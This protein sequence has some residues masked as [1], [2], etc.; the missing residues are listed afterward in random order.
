MSLQKKILYHGLPSILACD[1]RCD[2]AWGI[3]N[4]PRLYFQES[5]TEPRALAKGEEPRHDDD[6]V[7][8]GDGELGIAPADPGTYECDDG[9]PSATPLIG[10]S[11]MNKWC[12]RECE[13]SDIV[14]EG[15]IIRLPNLELP[16]PNHAYPVSSQ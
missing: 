10:P 15:E 16:R 7:Y 5:L 1:G 13:R 4:R 12:A 14:E 2:K 3:N 11:H 9:K 8:I 6:Y